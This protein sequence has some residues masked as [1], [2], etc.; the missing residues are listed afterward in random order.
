[1]DV[2]GYLIVFFCGTIFGIAC[3]LFT[4]RSAYQMGV[5][6]GFGYA[7]DPSNERFDGVAGIVDDV[8]RRSIDEIDPADYWKQG[9]RH[10]ED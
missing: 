3:K 6:D 1:M 4:C 8:P 2:I 9:K 7:H 5:K 10:D